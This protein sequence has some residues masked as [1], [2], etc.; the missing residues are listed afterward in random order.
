MWQW[1]RCLLVADRLIY[2]GLGE[3]RGE[4][5]ND[6]WVT[7]TYRVDRCGHCGSGVTFFEPTESLAHWTENEE[8]RT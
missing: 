3:D 4:M 1:V 5:F 6:L 8:W 7:A 2:M